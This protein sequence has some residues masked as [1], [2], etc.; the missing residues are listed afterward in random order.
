MYLH[1]GEDILV[2]TNEVIAILDKQLLQSSP[3]ILE[4][5]KEKEEVTLNLSK[6]SIKSIVVTDEHIYYSPLSSGTLKKRS[7]QKAI[8]IDE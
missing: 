4:F 6:G 5:L 7:L 8:L 2:K 3:L 1:I